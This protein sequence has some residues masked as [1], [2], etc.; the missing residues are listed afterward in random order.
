MRLSLTDVRR[1][2]LGSRVR[3]TMDT[4]T[5]GGVVFAG[6]EEAIVVQHRLAAVAGCDVLI[7]DVATDDGRH[8]FSGF[9]YMWE[10]VAG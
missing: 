7:V 10:P 4:I 5:V 6:G 8:F 1:F 9:G 2:P 3:F